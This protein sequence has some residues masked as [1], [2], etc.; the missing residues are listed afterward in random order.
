MY[1]GDENVALAHVAEGWAKVKPTRDGSADEELVLA[2]RDAQ[3]RGVGVWT[4]NPTEAAAASRSA[5]AAFDA[6]FFAANRGAPRAVSRRC[7]TVACVSLTV[8]ARRDARRSWC[9]SRGCSAEHGQRAAA[10]PSDGDR[11]APR[12]ET[13]PEPFARRSTSRRLALHRDATLT[14]EGE[15]KYHNLYATFSFD[16]APNVDVAE[17]LTRNGLARVADWSAALVAGGAARLR[18]AE[19]AAKASRARIW[20][21][22]VPPP[23]NSISGGDFRAVVVEA[24]SGDVVVVAH[25]ATGAERRVNLSSIR[26]PRLGNERRGQ[27]PEPWAVE[28][29]E[30]LRQRC[31]GREVLVK[32]EYIRKIGGG[33]GGGGEDASRV[34][35]FG[36]VYLPGE[37]GSEKEGESLDV[38]ECGA[39]RFGV[40]DAPRGDRRSSRYD[41]SSPRNSAPRRPKAS[42]T[43]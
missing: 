43:E 15:D 14:L 35:E 23:D 36:G 19:K 33:D 8:R 18:A 5:P 24:V 13:Q 37:K 17:E 16:D 26:A 34:L 29:K 39:S 4:R 7:S 20:R 40:G 21:E 41:A 1:L 25:I 27:R 3:A 10:E 28:A 11:D 2:E 12:P 32:M 30:F 42:R 38:A 22:Y 31:V 6:A 9:I